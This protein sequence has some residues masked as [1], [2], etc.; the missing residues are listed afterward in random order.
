MNLHPDVVAAC[1]RLAIQPTAAKPVKAR[2]YR[3]EP[4][5]DG[6]GRRHASKKE[7]RRWA[8]L[9]MLQRTGHIYGLTHQPPYDLVVN[10]VLIGRYTADSRYV[11]VKTGQVIVE[12]CK[13]PASKTTAY[14]LRRKL[15][16]AI[17]GVDVVEV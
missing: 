11:D 7:A 16:K 4:V 6:E 14:K 2:K 13:S 12:D 1:E 17:H 9:Q 8:E 3:N 15:M 10:G 5:I